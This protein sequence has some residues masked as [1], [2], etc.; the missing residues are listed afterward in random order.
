MSHE[1]HLAVAIALRKAIWNWVEVF[2]DEFND[3]IR[4]RGRME[5][6]PERVFDLLYSVAKD[7]ERVI[8]PTLTILTCTSSDRIPSDLDAGQY[9]TRKPSKKVC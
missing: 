3:T 6:A 4:S 5:G 8:W 2:P 9:G 1:A 7:A